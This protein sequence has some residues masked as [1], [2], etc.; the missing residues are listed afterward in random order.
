M[1]EGYLQHYGVL[2]MKWGIRKAEKRGTT[3]S[4]TSHRTN[5]Y[6][7]IATKAAAKGNTE[8]AAKYSKYA[9]RSAQLDKNKENFARSSN[10]V[11]G[12]VVR[13][14][15]GI[16]AGAGVGAAAGYAATMGARSSAA[17]RAADRL[18]KA[19]KYASDTLSAT[20]AAN[21]ARA[22]AAA[23]YA[24]GMMDKAAVPGAL[25]NKVAKGAS[26]NANSLGMYSKFAAESKGY[27]DMAGAAVSAAKAKNAAA[28]SAAIGRGQ[29]AVNSATAYGN[30]A[31]ARAAASTKIATIGAAG[32]GA[33]IAAVGAW[34]MTKAY[35]SHRSFGDSKAKAALKSVAGL[36]VVGS[37][38]REQRYIRGG[39]D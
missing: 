8:K 28:T 32:A 12:N 5:K 35:Q 24:S 30:S 7:K 14:V 1:G 4:Y 3:Y 36:G 39:N 9:E 22:N 13:K 11:A 26:Y 16:G 38:I 29:A 19:H 20:N 27:S 15:A 18:A 2:G 6:N 34:S 31:I 23:K 17:A 37:T 10:S 33:A 25:A 21:V